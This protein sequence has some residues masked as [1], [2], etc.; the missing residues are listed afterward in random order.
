VFRTPA[1]GASAEVRRILAHPTTQLVGVEVVDV[2]MAPPEAPAPEEPP[3]PPDALVVARGDQ[4]SFIPAELVAES[5]ADRRNPASS[6][7][8]P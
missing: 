1:P 5:M 7:A 2:T 4:S 3:L 6:S 8:P